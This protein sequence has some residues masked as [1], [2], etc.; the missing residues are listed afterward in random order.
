MRRPTPIGLFQR[1]HSVHGIRVGR[2]HKGCLVQLPPLDATPYIDASFIPK[3]F[4]ED[5]NPPPS[6]E[7]SSRGFHNGWDSNFHREL[8]VHFLSTATATW[9]LLPRQ[10]TYLYKTKLQSVCGHKLAGKP[11]VSDAGN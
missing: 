4:Q 11:A 10:V 7:P 2:N 8:P 6:S 3:P 1:F 9:P 5:R